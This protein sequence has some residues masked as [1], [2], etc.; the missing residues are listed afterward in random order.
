ML[1]DT[2]DLVAKLRAEGK[3]VFVH[4]VRAESRTPSVAATWLVRHHQI[5]PKTAI[6]TVSQAMNGVAL[7]HSLRTAIEALSD[8]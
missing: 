2:A 3:R 1:A 7:R 6:D 5:A 4:C 8:Q